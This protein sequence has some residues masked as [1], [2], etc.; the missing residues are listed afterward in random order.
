MIQAFLVKASVWLTFFGTMAELA[1]KSLLE[2]AKLNDSTDSV[3][4]DVVTLSEE[5]LSRHD[6]DKAGVEAALDEYGQK[7][8]L[9]MTCASVLD[10]I[11]VSGV[12][13]VLSRAGFTGIAEAGI[14][15]AYGVSSYASFYFL[16]CNRKS[17]AMVDRVMAVLKTAFEDET[18]DEEAASDR[19]KEEE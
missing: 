15:A 6:P 3:Y 17:L 5:T 16:R 19:S 13:L 14:V 11:V 4:N 7:F 1:G 12:Y 10:I 9:L 8:D 18:A 2:F